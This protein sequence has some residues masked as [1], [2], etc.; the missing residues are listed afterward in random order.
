MPANVCMYGWMPTIRTT[1]GTTIGTTIVATIPLIMATVGNPR[2]GIHELGPRSGPRDGFVRLT[3]CLT[4][5]MALRCSVPIPPPCLRFWK[6]LP[7]VWKFDRSH[8]SL[9]VGIVAKSGQLIGTT[10]EVVGIVARSGQL[11]A[12]HQSRCLQAL[13]AILMEKLAAHQP[14]STRDH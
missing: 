4:K 2:S 7:R 13:T 12:Q 11:L 1:I 9:V 5:C 3:L 10:P 8:A 14:P 6:S